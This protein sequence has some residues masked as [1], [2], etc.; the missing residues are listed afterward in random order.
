MKTL[1]NNVISYGFV[2]ILGISAYINWWSLHPELLSFHEQNQMFLFTSE[3]FLERIVVAGGLSD[4][5]GEFLVQFFYYASAGAAIMAALLMSFYWLNHI[6]L[7]KL[8][9]DV[10][11]GS[12]VISLLAT[13]LM[14]IN[15]MD[16]NT[17][18]SY[19]MAIILSLSTFLLCRRGGWLVQLVA[20]V[21]LYWIAGPLFVVQVALALIDLF[22]QKEWKHA[23]PASGMMVSTA[24]GW[25]YLCRTW[26]VAQYPWKTVLAGI[27]YHRLTL[28]TLETPEIQYT[29]AGV[30]VFAPMAL[31]LLNRLRRVSALVACYLLLA[32]GITTQYICQNY[33]HDSN[34]HV[35]LEQTYQIRKGDWNGVITH[36][37]QYMKE[38]V[39][40]VE[41]PLSGTAVNLSLAMTGHLSKR[42]FEFPQTGQ[43]SLTMPW[44]RDNISCATTM[45]AFFQLGFINESLRYAFDLQES[46]LNCRKS[47]RFTRRMAECNI[48]NGRYDV[49]SK[50]IDQ[51]KH[52][53]FYSDWAVQAEKYL[54]NEKMIASHPGWNEKRQ[55]RLE[56]DFLYNINEMHKMLGQLVLHNRQNTLAYDYF[57]ADL[58]LIGD[59]RSYV[60][61]L[62]QQPQAGTDPFPAG[63]DKYVEKMRHAPAGMSADAETG[64]TSSR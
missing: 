24:V 30:L 56:S 62:P 2:L 21:P 29:I 11:G 52:T 59:Y 40:A 8:L 18:L 9:H 44:T 50:Y 54:Y 61:N 20:S 55:F 41:S 25:V 14:W 13:A 5:L 6:V 53:L 12:I 4:Y 15:L 58:L 1:S 22:R 49:A 47:G 45:E 23:L 31:L 7:R 3:Y 46:I 57:M 48:I 19:P 10:R 38:G 37:E 63:Y 32:I 35:I 43:Q 16:E 28:M 39:A 36:A 60:A 51:L 26:W 64:A 42:I 27:N 34:V 17:M 33:P